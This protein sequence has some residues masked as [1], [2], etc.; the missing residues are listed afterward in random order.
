MIV[1]KKPRWTYLELL[2]QNWTKIDIREKGIKKVL[3]G[4]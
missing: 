1:L 4:I 2:H 3:K